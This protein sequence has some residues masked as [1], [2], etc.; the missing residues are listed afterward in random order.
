MTTVERVD[1]TFLADP[2]LSPR[3]LFALLARMLYDEGYDEHIAGHISYRQADD[4][5]L[6]NPWEMGW[7]EVRASD[8]MRIDLDGKIIDGNWG[9]TPAIQ[10]HLALHRARKDIAV[11]V[12]HHPRYG[13]VYAAAGRIPDAYDQMGALV[14]ADRIAVLDEYVGTVDDADSARRN[15]EALADAD[16]AF[17][18]NHGVMVVAESIEKAYLRATALESR[19]KRAWQI[20]AIGGGRPF[21]ADQA[22]VLADKVDAQGGGPHMFA[23]MVRRQVRIDPTVLD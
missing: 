22:K 20:E 4:T 15:V 21:P 1:T 5:V 10:L 23:A 9:V 18:A 3:Q 13:T 12:H 8:V 11:G 2:A 19:C 7:N 14:R 16:V 17:L 6:V